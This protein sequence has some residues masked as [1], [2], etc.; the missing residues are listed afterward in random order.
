MNA[1]LAKEEKDFTATVVVSDGKTIY[2]P[3]WDEKKKRNKKVP[4]RLSDCVQFE[5]EFVHR[6]LM[7][8][9]KTKEEKRMR[10]K[11]EIVKVEETEFKTNKNDIVKNM[12]HVNVNLE[13]LNVLDHL[14]PWCMVHCL[15][16]CFCRFKAVEGDRFEFGNTKID[17]IEQPAYTK[18]RQYTFEK[19]K[20]ESPTKMLKISHPVVTNTFTEIESSCRRVR[21]VAT[22]QYKIVN[23]ARSV[24]VRKRIKRIE[25]EHPGLKILLRNR[26]KRSTLLPEI[27]PLVTVSDERIVLNNSAISNENRSFTEEN[28]SQPFNECIASVATEE[29]LDNEINPAPKTSPIKI[30]FEHN[31]H[32]RKYRPRFNNI[33]MKTMQGIS[34][35]LRTK[36]GLPSPVNKALN[37]IQ[38]KHFLRA[39]NADQIYIW[40]VQLN[41]QEVLLVVTD[42]NIMPIVSNAIYV[43][44]I[45]AVSTERLPVLPKLIKL[46][47]VNEETEKMSVLLFGVSNYWRVLGC[48]HSEKDFLNNRVVAIPTPDTNPLLASKIS[49]LFDS[50]VQLSS[51]TEAEPMK[52][53][54]SSINSNICIRSLD[55]VDIDKI[56]VPIPVIGCHRWL[57]LSLYNDFSHIFVPPWKHF[58]TYDQIQSATAHAK[59]T[60]KTV[61]M[62]P[63]NLTLHVY[64][65]H[66]S[67][68]KIFF[69]PLKKNETLSLQLL[70]NFDG[71][72]MLREDY[73]RIV[74][75]K[76]RGLTIGTW[77]YMKDD[78]MVVGGNSSPETAT[79]SMFGE[80]NYPSSKRTDVPKL[81]F[82]TK[83]SSAF[84]PL[85]PS[86]V[87]SNVN[88]TMV[89]AASSS[90]TSTHKLTTSVPSTSSA[91]PSSELIRHVS[92]GLR[93]RPSKVSTIVSS[94]T[95]PPSSTI[96]N[97]TESHAPST[98]SMRAPLL[99][100]KTPSLPANLASTLTHVMPK[101]TTFN[102]TETVTA[103]SQMKPITA[104]LAANTPCTNTSIRQSLS[105]DILTRN[106]QI[107]APIRERRYTTIISG[108]VKPSLKYFPHKPMNDRLQTSIKNFEL[109]QKS[110]NFMA[111]APIPNVE[112]TSKQMPCRPLV[113]KKIDIAAPVAKP[114]LL[115]QRSKT[116]FERPKPIQIINRSSSP[117]FVPMR[118]HFKTI[119]VSSTVTSKQTPPIAVV[120]PT[121]SNLNLPS[122]SINN[123]TVSAPKPTILMKLPTLRPILPK[124]EKKMPS[125]IPIMTSP[126]MTEIIDCDDD[127]DDEDDGNEPMQ[128]PKMQQTLINLNSETTEYPISGFLV[129]PVHRLGKIMAKKLRE[130]YT[131]ILPPFET[132]KYF[133][134]FRQCND[135]LNNMYDNDCLSYNCSQFK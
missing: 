127:D 133:L 107:G 47:I 50:M 113:I 43:I 108:G 78:H 14:Q 59:K 126:I 45:K 2:V 90:S 7:E 32:P 72:M 55:E 6:D 93:A 52:V 120:K 17:M 100:V 85:N 101:I 18:K 111:L 53:S 36:T 23:R 8:T 114:S 125:I 67:D 54:S 71:K 128:P 68:M 56:H 95:S 62:G 33:I 63:A 117:S 86:T 135:Y 22:K 13:R 41:T 81:N 131:V 122:S 91:V 70:Q 110:G 97:S 57:M 112:S 65:P 94:I 89:S 51:K 48:T 83:P 31:E 99:S 106:T 87:T 88:I 58:L 64:V 66:N 102:R 73:Q 79:D 16:K 34:Q 38:W 37:C 84:I 98:A 60:Q 9:F 4:K 27:G 49:N 80:S 119:P 82:F 124:I 40:E 74:Q 21:V 116:I 115:R 10:E 77:L 109:V 44:N 134:N 20:D 24:E 129:S 26:V 19:N 69:G 130:G 118:N 15:Y 46:G 123:V 1:S 3:T 121:A 76:R 25:Q 105:K 75:P 92:L 103:T 96:V 11:M 132:T 28:Q 61:R 35:R 29:Q 104:S 12:I 5:S 30:S 39:F 42:K